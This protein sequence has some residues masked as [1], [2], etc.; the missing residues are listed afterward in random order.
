MKTIKPLG[1][2]FLAILAI[3]TVALTTT[4]SAVLLAEFLPTP[5]ATSPVTFTLS[6]GKSE[7]VPLG[8]ELGNKENIKCEKHKGSGELTSPKLGKGEIIYEGCE[9]AATASKCETLESKKPGVIT[10]KGALHIQSGLLEKVE[11]GKL[12]PTLVPALVLL[13]EALHFTCGIFLFQILQS[14]EAPSCVA[15][16]LLEPNVLLKTVKVDF[17]EEKETKGDQD[18]VKVFNS[19][20]KEY[21]CK[22]FFSLNEGKTQ[23]EALVSEK[24]LEITGFT[25]GKAAITALIDF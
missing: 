9:L 8:N 14:S 18:I 23:D 21:E 15:G 17:K 22:L 5:S 19:E 7:P 1:M 24:E 11:G 13:P 4:A 10:A 16:E 3:N 20:D 2:A 25:Q 6:G 12:V